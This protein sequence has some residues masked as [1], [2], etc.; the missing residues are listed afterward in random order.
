MISYTAQQQADHAK[1]SGLTGTLYV[2]THRSGARA[3]PKRTMT[4]AALYIIGN[5]TPK[6]WRIDLVKY[7]DTTV[8]SATDQANFARRDRNGSGC[9]G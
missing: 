5:S 4:E 8:L 7:E 9:N 2:P 6:D 3:L 1:N